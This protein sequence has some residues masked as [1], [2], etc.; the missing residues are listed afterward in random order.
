MKS[1]TRYFVSVVA[2]A[3]VAKL[4]A[5]QDIDL[6]VPPSDPVGAEVAKMAAKD[7][8]DVERFFHGDLKMQTTDPSMSGGGRNALLMYKTAADTAAYVAYQP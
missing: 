8:R 4:A 2:A 3:C 5:A 7:Q 6:H 1:Q